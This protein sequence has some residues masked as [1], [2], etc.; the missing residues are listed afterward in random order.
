MIRRSFVKPAVAAALFLL[1][2]AE[3]LLPDL[4]APTPSRPPAIPAPAAEKISD[5]EVAEWTGTILA[6]PLLNQ[7]RRPVRPPATDDSGDAESFTLPR[8][9]AIII[10]GGAR[11]AVFAAP[12]EKPQLVAE[13]GD[14]GPYRLKTIAPDRVDML[15]PNGPTTLRPQ[16]VTAPAAN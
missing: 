3:W 2:A 6:R 12:G 4:Q 13:G 14:I 16:F 9:S 15:G 5:A 1:F 8:L 10:I 11:E 7:D